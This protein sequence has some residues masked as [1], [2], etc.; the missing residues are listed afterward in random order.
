MDRETQAPPPAAGSPLLVLAAA[1]PLLVAVL[2]LQLFGPQEGPLTATELATLHTGLPSGRFLPGELTYVAV[3]AVHFCACLAALWVARDLLRETHAGAGYARVAAAMAVVLMVCIPLGA[4]VP[5]ATVYALT[6][7]AFA[8]EFAG[9]GG[10]SFFGEAGFAG[11]SPLV[12]GMLLPTWAGVAAVAAIA[13]AAHA[14]LRKFPPALGDSG[15]ARAAYVAVVH[16]RLKRCLVVLS[17]VLVTSTVS[18]SL[19]FH[20]P[21]G[22]PVA[23]GT[24]QAALMERLTA[25]ASELSFFWGCIYTLTL[26]AA[27][28]LP[29][30]LFQQRV[31]VRVEQLAADLAAADEREG[32]LKA[33]VISGSADQLKFVTTLFAPLAAGP[34]ANLFQVG[35]FF[36]S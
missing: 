32:L 33:A 12:L 17:I 26:A 30:L 13:A 24:P 6:Y 28:G 16:A 2:L 18:A 8:S 10:A 5:G 25:F 27:V 36:S 29:I 14:Q 4:L 21:A 11:I 23:K 19:F 15:V 31:A 3:L 7:G 1:V 9:A 35:S 34:I 20:L 22:L